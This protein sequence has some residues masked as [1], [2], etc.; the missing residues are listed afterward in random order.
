M[1]LLFF[2]KPHYGGGGP[3]GGGTGGG[4]H[5]R[6]IQIYEDWIY[7]KVQPKKAKVNPGDIH[8]FFRE[9]PELVPQVVELLQEGFELDEILLLF[10]MTER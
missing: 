9:R 5:K 2:L 7:D 1:T 4:D 3:A 8:P 10:M 6:Q